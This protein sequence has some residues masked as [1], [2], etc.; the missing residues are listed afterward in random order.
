MKIL[1]INEYFAP[2]GGT[3]QYLLP[4]CRKLEGMGHEIAVA[5]G[6]ETGREELVENRKNYFIPNTLSLHSGRNQVGLKKLEAVVRSENPDLIYIHQVHNP[7]AIKILTKD[8]PC[9][10]YF[11]GYKIGCP[12]GHRSLLK[13]DTLCE[14]PVAYRCIVRAYTERC[15]PRNIFKSNRLVRLSFANLKANM[16]IKRFIVASKYMRQMLA[17][18]GLPEERIEVIPY[19]TDLP[20]LSK[21]TR[22]TKSPSNI[23]FFGRLVQPK[24][25]QYLIKA[26]EHIDGPWKCFII[27]E[28]PELKTIQD[29]TRKLQISENIQ[30]TGWQPH[31]GLSKYYRQ[32]RVVVVPSV[33]PEPFCIV[34]IEAMSYG[35]PVVAFDVGGISDWLEDSHT[36]FLVPRLDV[37]ELARKIEML[38]KDKELAEKFGKQGRLNVENRF[39]KDIHLK[40]LMQVFESV[41]E[42]DFS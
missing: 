10:R 9:V 35:K 41:R 37:M 22:E 40:K 13:S 14:D 38:L 11:H 29:L 8:K 33:W 24:G 42:K 27:G 39:T 20:S 3:E 18:N 31:S 6:M 12:A 26:L 21:E 16:Q 30:F 19:Y 25:L 36:G 15:M 17:N 2:V 28:G 32:A 4:L 23:L 7:Y 1:I 34:G 5:Y